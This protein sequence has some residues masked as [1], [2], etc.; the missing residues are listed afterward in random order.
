[1]T[2]Y[3]YCHNVASF[4]N[5]S[6]Y[7]WDGATFTEK[8]HL[9]RHLEIFESIFFTKTSYLFSEFIPIEIEYH[10]F[11]GL[12]IMGEFA[13]SLANSCFF[14]ISSTFFTIYQPHVFEAFDLR[15]S[16]QVQHIYY[17]EL[18]LTQPYHTIP[19]PSEILNAPEIAHHWRFYSIEGELLIYN[20]DGYD[21][22]GLDRWG[23][24]SMGYDEDD[25]DWDGVHETS[26]DSADSKCNRY[27]PYIWD[28]GDVTNPYI[29]R[30]LDF[31]F[32]SFFISALLMT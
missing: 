11:Q 31:Y 18:I 27:D 2:F 3:A 4:Y 24:N 5:Q 14:D 19:H 9:D 1:M 17:T 30:F 22:Y 16:P 26:D 7:D 12:I 10:D 8:V 6:S 32:T 23:F 28:E 15:S 21:Q 25:C 20:E 29:L 13:D